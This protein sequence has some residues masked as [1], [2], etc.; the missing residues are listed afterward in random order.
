MSPTTAPDICTGTHWKQSVATWASDWIEAVDAVMQDKGLTVRLSSLVYGGSPVAIPT[1]DD[2]PFIGQWP[3][4]EVAAAL[5]AFESLD[6][7][8]FDQEMAETFAQ[9]HHWVKAAAGNEGA[10]VLGFLS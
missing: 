5:K 10:K 2:Y 8:D 3:P 9:M 1:P 7:S 6:T 4:G